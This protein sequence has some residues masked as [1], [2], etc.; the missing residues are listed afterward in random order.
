MGN[1]GWLLAI[2]LTLRLV[3][4]AAVAQTPPASE[5]GWHFTYN[6]NKF[7]GGGTAFKLD[8]DGNYYVET[9]GVL[10]RQHGELSGRLSADEL[11]AFS[12]LVATA[13]PEAWSKQYYG[14][15]CLDFVAVLNFA[16]PATGSSAITHWGCGLPGLPQDLRDLIHAI[17]GQIERAIPETAT[18]E[19][20]T[21]ERETV[22]THSGWTIAQEGG[23]FRR[24]I[25]IAPDGA[26]V[27]RSRVGTA[28]CRRP[29]SRADRS[30]AT[31][32]ASER[33]ASMP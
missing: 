31:V 2:V 6:V 7:I 24:T 1:S 25:R 33:S 5:P 20:P 19:F 14:P 32:A 21:L 18:D 12:R 4:S 9:V 29:A 11:A 8:Q 13:R 26:V 22:E 10:G 17:R 27:S 3:S 15:T 23:G 16:R 28:S 30:I